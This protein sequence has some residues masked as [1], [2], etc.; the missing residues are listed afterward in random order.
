MPLK[1][2]H[3]VLNIG[4]LLVE[5]EEGLLWQRPVAR[6]GSM[7]ALSSCAG[8]LNRSARVNGAR[9]INSSIGPGQAK[10]V[11]RR[12]RSLYTATIVFGVFC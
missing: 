1:I 7:A 9:A 4:Y 2:E 11:W 3:R 10:D 12:Y 5:E 6:T 8:V